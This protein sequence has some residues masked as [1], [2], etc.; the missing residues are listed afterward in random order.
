MAVT[1]FFTGHG[2]FADQCLALDD[3]CLPVPDAMS[4]AEAAGFLIPFHT[5]WVAL[6]RR[7]RLE[8]GETLL[9]VGGSG[10]TGQAAIQVGRALGARVIAT[11]GGADRVAFCRGLGAEHVI[12]RRRED[13]ARAVLDATEGR[14]ADAIFDPVGGEAFDAATRCIA[15]EGRILAVGFASG[16]WGR[17][18]PAHLVTHNYSVV[19]VIP[20]RYDRAFKERAQEQLVAW[21]RAGRLRSRV[22]RLVPFAELPQALERLLA[23]AVTGKLALAVSPDASRPA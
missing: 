5:A 21:W 8:A 3:F 23:G 1:R 16:T 9:V 11:A 6:A 14:G 2:G 7:G 18:D 20:S 10:G 4:D 22:D 17:V 12:D 15:H 19:G 13:I